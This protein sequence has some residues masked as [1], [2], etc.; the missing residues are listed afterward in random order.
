MFSVDCV[1][2]GSQ[3]AAG[4]KQRNAFIQN[5]IGRSAVTTR[6]QD[7]RTVMQEKFVPPQTS[8]ATYFMTKVFTTVTCPRPYLPPVAQAR[9][10]QCQCQ[11]QM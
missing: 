10:C 4:L 1:G 2:P 9:F 5:V 6:F 8:M 11:C 3:S 7:S